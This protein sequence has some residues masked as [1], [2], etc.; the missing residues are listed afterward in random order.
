[1]HASIGCLPNAPKPNFRRRWAIARFSDYALAGIG[2]SCIAKPQ[3][4]GR[5][6]PE[7]LRVSN[8]GW[9]W[10][11]N[12]ALPAKHPCNDAFAQT[13]RSVRNGIFLQECAQERTLMPTKQK[14]FL[15]LIKAAGRIRH[16]QCSHRR[17]RLAELVLPS[18][19]RIH[20]TA[21]ELP[22]D[23][24]HVKSLKHLAWS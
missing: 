19:K 13:V 21:W 17:G 10:K 2:A 9:K 8:V 3:R 6:R 4:G 15:S 18:Q 12:P 5:T 23:V 1:M 22:A 7:L 20:L 16:R 11:C 24:Q 14:V